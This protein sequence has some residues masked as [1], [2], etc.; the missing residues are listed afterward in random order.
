MPN[1]FKMKLYRVKMGPGIGLLVE[2]TSIKAHSLIR[3]EGEGGYLLIYFL[4]ED[5][6]VP[7]PPA[8]VRPDGNSGGICV[9][10]SEMP[11]YMD[12]IRN[13]DP[14][15]IVLFPDKPEYNHIATAWEK[16][17]SGDDPW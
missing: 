12:M 6:P 4:A 15:Y 7:N 17:G 1:D 16:V 9:P 13:E 10:M 3:I 2:G 14:I 11:A 5:S 8:F